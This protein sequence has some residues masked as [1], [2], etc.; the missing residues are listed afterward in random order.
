MTVILA[1]ARTLPAPDTDL[2]TIQQALHARGI[3]ARIEPWDADIDWTQVSLCV[4]R[5]T[6]D[7]HHRLPEFLAWAEKTSQQTRLLNPAAVLRWNTRKTYLR[8]LELKGIP[9]VPTAWVERGERVDLAKLARERGWTDVVVKPAVSAGAQRTVRFSPDNAASAQQVCD[10]ITA[11]SNGC[12]AMV[13][14]Y[15]RAVEGHGER[16]LLFFDRQFSH[17]IRKQPAL[18]PDGTP[19]APAAAVAPEKDELQLADQVL[20]AV[21]HELLYARVD[22][23]RDADGTVRLMEL[24]VTEPFLFLHLVPGAVDRLVDAIRSKL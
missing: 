17:A 12:E 3:D 21:P 4:I 16:S 2:P 7:Y 1:T 19:N 22:T 15:L 23:V 18:A 13:Q 8:E 11:G 10:E 9:M 6:W 5:S 24:E 20:G 14:P